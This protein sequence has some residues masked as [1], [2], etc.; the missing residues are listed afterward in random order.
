MCDSIFL[1]GAGDSLIEMNAAPY[2]SEAL[3][4]QWLKEWPN[5]LAGA[6]VN[7]EAPRQ[8]LFV[9]REVGIPGEEEGSDQWS[10]DH[11]FL[12]QDGIPTFVEVKRSSDTRLRREVVGQMLDYAANAV[13]YWP[14]DLIRQRAEARAAK[15]EISPEEMLATAFRSD[16][17]PEA[18]WAAVHANVRE[19]RI[20]LLFV[21][22][23]IPPELRRIVEFLNEQMDPAEVL[24]LEL[25]QYVG[26]DDKKTF[27]P[28]VFGQTVQAEQKLKQNGS[29]RGERWT[30]ARF[31]EV[32]ADRCGEES[33]R[34][35]R[36]I[37]EWAKN[38]MTSV[39][40]G[41]GRTWGT[42]GAG[43]T[44]GPTTHYPFCV[45]TYGRIK[46]FC[47]WL[48]TRPPFS[49][50]CKRKELLDRL[51]GIDGV[52]LSNEGQ[53]SISLSVLAKSNALEQL[54]RVLEWVLEEIKAC[55]VFAG[56]KAEEEASITGNP[57][58]VA[59]PFDAGALAEP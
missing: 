14:P 7:P 19:R 18:Y 13:V 30:E 37:L 29:G 42:F 32:L 16:V 12:D 47:R 46:I 56:G 40:W 1:L 55:S 53:A 39:W 22:D 26:A 25:K 4:Q 15:D 51:N 10:L 9:A 41:Q 24:A 8:W 50:E 31:Y 33:V 3:L 52:G 21:A 6:Q 11:L 49:D 17:D 45:Y 38:N 57:A 43:I 36:A 2:D 59:A 23:L 35:A 20:R 58:E 27:V 28:R 5:L 34:V 54:L 44:V 48:R